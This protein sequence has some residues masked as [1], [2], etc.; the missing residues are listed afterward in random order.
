MPSRD[1]EARVIDLEILLTH[2]QRDLAELNAQLIEQRRLIEMLQR[3]I[4]RL[5]SQHS[6]EQAEAGADS[7]LSA[8]SFG[9]GVIDSDLADE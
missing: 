1:L 3:Q 9:A 6:P 8:P 4:G 2:Q 5:E 7:D